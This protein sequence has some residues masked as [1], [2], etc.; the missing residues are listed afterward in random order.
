MADPTR[1]RDSVVTHELPAVERANDCGDIFGIFHRNHHVEREHQAAF[2]ELL[3]DREPLLKSQRRELVYTSPT[4]LDQCSDTPIPEVQLQ[5]VAPI[6]FDLV[7][8][9]NVEVVEI[10]VGKFDLI[11]KLI[12]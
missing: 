3:R 5:G 2:E 12:N 9:V 8:L 11:T 1:Q 7:V 6:R 4:P 10:G